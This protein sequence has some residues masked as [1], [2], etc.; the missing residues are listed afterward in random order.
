MKFSDKQL[1]LIARRGVVSEGGLKLVA[2][3]WAWPYLDE[4]VERMPHLGSPQQTRGGLKVRSWS[5]EPGVAASLRGLGLVGGWQ[6]DRPG[7]DARL[8]GSVEFWLGVLDVN[9]QM[10]GYQDIRLATSKVVLEQFA[11]FVR[12]LVPGWKGAPFLFKGRWSCVVQGK[13]V[14]VFYEELHR[15]GRGLLGGN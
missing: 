5:R 15:R 13:L 8:A 6:E 12:E 3:D 10:A 1:G 2:P 7:V 14:G 4:V 9:Q 11:E